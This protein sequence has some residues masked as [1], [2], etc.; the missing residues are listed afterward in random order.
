MEK[1]S[2]NNEKNLI[3]LMNIVNSIYKL[4]ESKSLETLTSD[5]ETI[6]VNVLDFI[7]ENIND[8][9]IT[10]Q[11]FKKDFSKLETPHLNTKLIIDNIEGKYVKQVEELKKQYELKLSKETDNS[12][13]IKQLEESIKKL[14]EMNDSYTEKYSKMKLNFDTEKSELEHKIILLKSKVNNTENSITVDNN[15]EIKRLNE[16]VVSLN[17]KIKELSDKLDIQGNIIEEKEEELK[18]KEDKI[19]KLTKLNQT[20]SNLE[21]KTSIVDDKE[22]KDINKYKQEIDELKD[23]IISY[24]TEISILKADNDTLTNKSDLFMNK[25]KELE[26]ILKE[27][28]DNLEKFKENREKDIEIGRKE[29]EEEYKNKITKIEEEK[30]SIE[31]KLAQSNINVEL[32]EEKVNE[33]NNRI[34]KCVELLTKNNN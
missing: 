4:E 15:N 5:I 12:E 7:K 25:V 3:Q 1:T 11:E 17:E 27:E 8:F 32:F 16:L 31:I 20:I 21:D 29:L 2:K 14:K 34:N 33:L 23:K 10:N 9:S 28:R 19:N 22:I 24:N 6:R 18:S 30:N 13:Y 26:V